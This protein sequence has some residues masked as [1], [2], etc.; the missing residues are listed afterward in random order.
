[1]QVLN[2]IQSWFDAFKS[3]PDY[4][5]IVQVYSELKSKGIEFPVNNTDSTAPIYTP[6]RSASLGGRS[7]SNTDQSLTSSSVMPSYAR[8]PTV[9]Q[10]NFNP[11]AA[12]PISLNRDQLAKLRHELDIVNSNMKVF[13]EMLNEMTPGKEHAD[14]WKLLKDLNSTCQAM[15]KRIVDLV[16]K[17]TNEEI[18]SELLRL[19]DELNYLFERYERYERKK[20]QSMTSKPSSNQESS[21]LDLTS[22]IPNPTPSDVLSNRMQGLSIATTPKV[23]CCNNLFFPTSNQ[24][25]NCLIYLLTVLCDSC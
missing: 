19:N 3:Q 9:S 23:S 20:V 7:Y 8:P 1:L 21:L 22:D 12:T 13:A 11:N 2:L 25:S 4:S 16:E 10:A 18:T 5:G 6:Q 14:D 24:S 17:V 15:Q